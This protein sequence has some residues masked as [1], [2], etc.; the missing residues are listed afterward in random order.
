MPFIML[1]PIPQPPIPAPTTA[2]KKWVQYCGSSVGTK[3]RNSTT[4]TIIVRPNTSIARSSNR[5]D[6]RT[7]PT[8]VSDAATENGTIA[9]PAWNVLYPHTRF[10]NCG[11]IEKLAKMPAGITIDNNAVRR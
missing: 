4:P 11:I 3:R 5:F 1:R 2:G 8:A 9:R 7:T 6:A 10:K